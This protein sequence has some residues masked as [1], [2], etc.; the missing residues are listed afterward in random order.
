MLFGAKLNPITTCLFILK[1]LFLE[2]KQIP[3]SPQPAS[4]QETDALKHALTRAYFSKINTDLVARL[5]YLSKMPQET[6][7]MPFGYSDK[8]Q[9]NN[10]TETSLL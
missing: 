9:R 6:S 4:T 10:V 1:S 8:L 3:V 7:T 2:I 5:K